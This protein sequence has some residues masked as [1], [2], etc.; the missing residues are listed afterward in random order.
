[1]LV[2]QKIYFYYSKLQIT[3]K[4]QILCNVVGIKKV[5][6]SDLTSKIYNIY[7]LLFEKKKIEKFLSLYEKKPLEFSYVKVIR[8]DFHDVL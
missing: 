6:N 1:M 7:N 2:F 4:L 3:V 8:I 5:I